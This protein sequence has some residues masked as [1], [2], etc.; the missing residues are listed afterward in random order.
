MAGSIDRRLEALEEQLSVPEDE[1][2]RWAERE[3]LKRLTSE[4]LSWLLEPG[5]EA[6]NRVPCP[7]FEPRRC[8]CQCPARTQRGYEAH[9]ELEEERARR[10]RS[11]Y[12]RREEILAREPEG[13]AASWRRRHGIGAWA[14]RES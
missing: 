6:V 2:R 12:E 11:L 1:Q 13:F 5:Y 4:E 14:S 10:W 7:R 9:P 8:D 3:F